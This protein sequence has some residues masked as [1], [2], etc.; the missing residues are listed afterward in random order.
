MLYGGWE[1]SPKVELVGDTN[2]WDLNVGFVGFCEISLKTF[3]FDVII[4]SQKI[5]K[6]VQDSRKHPSFVS[7]L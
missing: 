4:D 5:A 3:S 2:L 6:I 1:S 7:I